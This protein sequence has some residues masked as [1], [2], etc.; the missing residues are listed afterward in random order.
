MIDFRSVLLCS[1]W[2]WLEGDYDVSRVFFLRSFSSV[3]FFGLF[4]QGLLVGEA[5][6]RAVCS[7]SF[8]RIH[9]HPSQGHR[10]VFCFFF[11]FALF[12]WF[13]FVYFCF[14]L[15]FYFSISP[16]FLLTWFLFLVF[17]NSLLFFFPQFFPL[18]FAFLHNSSLLLFSPGVCRCF[19]R[20]FPPQL[21]P[22]LPWSARDR[23]LDADRLPS[24]RVRLFCPPAPP[25]PV[26]TTTD[27]RVLYP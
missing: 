18:S 15:R 6:R 14:F 25:A 9:R 17:V 24:L 23:P 20:C 21:S 12:L 8:S 13:I 4:L 19:C 16:P 5:G 27:R 22:L 10:L 11:A 3:F 1:R 7:S 2:R 26:L